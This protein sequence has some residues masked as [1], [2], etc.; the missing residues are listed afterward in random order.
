MERRAQKNVR[1]RILALETCLPESLPFQPFD[2]LAANVRFVPN[3]DIRSTPP[4]PA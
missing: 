4:P 3:P 2:Y 1:N